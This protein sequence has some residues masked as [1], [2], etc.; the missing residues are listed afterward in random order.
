MKTF[1]C[2]ALLL[3]IVREVYITVP[4]FQETC[5]ALCAYDSHPNSSHPNF[6]PNI[7]FFENLPIYRRLIH[8]NISLVV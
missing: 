1:P 6:H 3:R 7:Y 8:D 5:S 2:G 4:L